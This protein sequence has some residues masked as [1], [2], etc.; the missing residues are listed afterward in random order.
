MKSL[1]TS[2]KN[3]ELQKIWFYMRNNEQVG[4]FS[5]DEMIGLMQNQIV[6]DFDYCWAPQL[7]NWTRLADTQEFQKSTLKLYYDKQ[8]EV[9]QKRQLPRIETSIPLFVTRDGQMWRGEI[10]SISE[11]GCSINSLDAYSKPGDEIQLHLAFYD[12]EIDSFNVKG[13]IISKQFTEIKNIKNQSFK[14]VV[15]FTEI[16]KFG[17][18]QIKQWIL[19]PLLLKK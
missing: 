5:Y 15:L 8:A 4:P 13:K 9:F 12:S 16:P 3:Q 2:D 17:T 10:G 14:Y 6:Y 18:E 7:T 11:K 1:E 19:N